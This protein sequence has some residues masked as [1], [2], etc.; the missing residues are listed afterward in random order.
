MSSNEGPSYKPDLPSWCSI[1]STPA[2]KASHMRTTQSVLVVDDAHAT[3]PLMENSL[4]E[5]N[6]RLLHAYTGK[7]ALAIAADQRPDLILL[8]VC[9]PDISGFDVCRALKDAPATYDIMVIF[10]SSA[11]DPV[12]KVRGL[13]LGATDYVTKPFDLAELRVRVRTSLRSK[14]LLDLLTVEARID[15]LTGLQNRR[16]FDCRL[17]QEMAQAQRSRQRLGLVLLDLDHFK[18]INDTLG[19]P[20]GD[21][22][23]CRVSELVTATCRTSDIPCRYGGDEFA[24]I[25]PGTS[26]AGCMEQAERLLHAIREDDRLNRLVNRPMTLSIG[27][28]S[29]NPGDDVDVAGLIQ[30]AD[31]ALYSAKAAGRNRA[32]A[33]DETRVKAAA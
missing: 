28:A 14:A 7:E 23:L 32:A 22:T 33:Y 26:A 30:R 13:E 31:E 4:R 15:G 3:H 29:A 10:V 1:R 27:C 25:L 24:L 5:L 16:Y 17:T 21:Q 12:D 6:L 8:D 19:H 20:I 11:D 9:L 18:Q 2:L